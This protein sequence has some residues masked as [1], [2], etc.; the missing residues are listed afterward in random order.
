MSLGLSAVIV[1][2]ITSDQA[3]LL[4]TTDSGVSTADGPHAEGWQL[5]MPFSVETKEGHAESAM[6]PVIL[7]NALR[8]PSNVLQ[9]LATPAW[10]V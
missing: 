6:A 10:P 5:G 3:L 2:I 1:Y 7:A 9:V 8:K 4:L